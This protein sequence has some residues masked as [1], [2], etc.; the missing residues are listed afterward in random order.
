MIKKEE[1]LKKIKK[2]SLEGVEGEKEA[3]EIMLKKLLDK[4]DISETSLDEDPETWC[5]YDYDMDIP[6]LSKKLFIKY[7]HLRSDEKLEAQK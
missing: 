6:D 4:F 1:L 3:A 5:C 2:L 7:L